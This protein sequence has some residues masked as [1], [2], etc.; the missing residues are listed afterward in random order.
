VDRTTKQSIRDYAI[1]MLFMAYGIRASK[2]ARLS[3]YD[4]APQTAIPEALFIVMKP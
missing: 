2:T 3:L 1:L 4:L